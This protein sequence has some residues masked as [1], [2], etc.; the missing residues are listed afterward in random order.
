M[1]LCLPSRSCYS[2]LKEGRER[3]V[4]AQKFTTASE[5]MSSHLHCSLSLAGY[6]MTL[7]SMVYI[8]Y[9]MKARSPL[10]CCPSVMLA[11]LRN[12]WSTVW[13]SLVNG[14]QEVN[15]VNKIYWLNQ[16]CV[17]WYI[18]TVII[19]ADMVNESDKN[20]CPTLWYTL[21]RFLHS[22]CFQCSNCI[23]WVVCMKIE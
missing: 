3:N 10:L 22:I 21:N 15:S 13:S 4:A 14:I 12:R 17:H 23:I 7:T 19:S 1:N 2:A 11:C 5:T 16:C 18:Y 6:Q 9:R 20:I 8:V